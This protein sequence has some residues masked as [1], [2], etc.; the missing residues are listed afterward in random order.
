MTDRSPTA[1]VRPEALD[2]GRLNANVVGTLMKEAV[3][4]AIVAIRARR[5]T[6]EATVKGRGVGGSPDM[7]T[8]ADHAA[9]RVYVKLLR[10]WFPG[11][12]ILA[13]EEGLRVPCT[14]SDHDL[15]FTVDPLD[16]TKAFIRRQSHSVGTMIALVC[17]GK[18][19]AA[20]I[21]D[22]M[23]QEVYAMRP[24]ANVVHRISEFGIAEALT[25][26]TTRSLSTQFLLLRG[27][28]DAYSPAVPVAVRSG[29]FRGY[30]IMGGSI[31]TGIARLWKSEMGAAL[32]LPAPLTPWDACP[33]LAPS[34]ALGFRF[35]EL[36]PGGELRQV[37]LDPTRDGIPLAR[38]TWLVHRSRI[39]ELHTWWRHA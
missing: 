4:R 30:E 36:L 15:W 35:L 5:F 31:G 11:F 34:L 23:T 16:G 29:L 20:C 3:R 10:E 32:F 22:V 7:V 12:G 33:L 8:S 2:F 38:E 14:R 37:Q 19:I 39:E 9:Q 25:I 6:F 24:G 13:E 18:A 1:T 17:D 27:P 26:D 21:G 28:P